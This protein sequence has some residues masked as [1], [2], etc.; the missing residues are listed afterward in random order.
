MTFLI[1]G[2]EI[3]L[4]PEDYVVKVDTTSESRCYSGFV[5]ADE[6]AN[7]S[8]HLGLVFLRRVYTVLEAPLEHS[9]HGR[10]GFAL[11]L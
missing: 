1:G 7:A 5:E 6:V 2:R 10:V 3:V 8:W 9:G 11:A 4:R